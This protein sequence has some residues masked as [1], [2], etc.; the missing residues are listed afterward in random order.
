MREWLMRGRKIEEEIKTIMAA[1]K[2]AVDKA[3]YAG[4]VI[5]GSGTNGANENKVEQK[6][7]QNLKFGEELDMRLEELDKV[8]TEILRAISI[9]P[10]PETRSMMIEYYLCGKCFRIIGKKMN[11]DTSTVQKRVAEGV[12]YLSK[13][14]KKK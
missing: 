8:K 9:V 1:K 4:I 2:A 12:R 11:Y 13:N 14:F 6:N 10:N 3:V 5:N 7:L